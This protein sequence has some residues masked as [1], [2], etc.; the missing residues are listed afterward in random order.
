[1]IERDREWEQRE[2]EAEA[3]THWRILHS[4]QLASSAIVC[5]RVQ[6]N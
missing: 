1:M 3:P 4:A 6:M 5:V 2:A